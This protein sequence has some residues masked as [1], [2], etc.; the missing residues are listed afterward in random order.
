[1][2]L[3]A[4]AQCVMDIWAAIIASNA[5]CCPKSSVSS[6]NKYYSIQEVQG[7]I[8]GLLFYA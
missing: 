3:V 5:V 4:V 6:I 7:I 8:K 1:M 2:L